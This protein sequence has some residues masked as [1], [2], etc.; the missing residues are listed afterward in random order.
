MVSI[1]NENINS[2]FEIDETKKEQVIIPISI[3]ILRTFA[4][5][6]LLISI[7]SSIVIWSNFST[8][9]NKDYL[10]GNVTNPYMIVLGIGV[11]LQGIFV[12]ALFLVLAHIAESLVFIRN[13]TK[14]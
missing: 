8:E 7:I 14:K 2:Q 9:A 12:C 10:G 11:L 13:N 4:W 1:M 3:W 6:D 5:L